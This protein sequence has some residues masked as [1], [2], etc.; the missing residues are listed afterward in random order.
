MR[1]ILGQQ[2]PFIIYNAFHRLYSLLEQVCPGP[3][4]V[5]ATPSVTDKKYHQIIYL[6]KTTGLK[7]TISISRRPILPLRFADDINTIVAPTANCKH[8]EYE[9]GCIS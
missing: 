6:T 5:Y 2:V 1:Q 9:T 3:Q 8:G 4:E 7:S